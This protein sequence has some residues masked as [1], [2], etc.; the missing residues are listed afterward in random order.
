MAEI[1][2]KFTAISDFKIGAVEV[3]HILAKYTNVNA[4]ITR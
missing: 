1:K 2:T 3:Y 4:L